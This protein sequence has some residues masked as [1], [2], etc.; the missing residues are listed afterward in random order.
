MP[1]IRRSR[2]GHGKQSAHYQRAQKH[3]FC[4]LHMQPPSILSVKI[5]R[6]NDSEVYPVPNGLVLPRYKPYKSREISQIA[7]C[8]WELR[9][10]ARFA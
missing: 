4:S 9:S 2:C 10:V 5:R 8:W 1:I 3:V 7:D 6:S